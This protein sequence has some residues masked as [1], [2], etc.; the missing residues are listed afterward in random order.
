MTK[1]I[2]TNKV[3]SK[4]I[5]LLKGDFDAD[6]G[7][8]KHIKSVAIFSCQSPTSAIIDDMTFE[9]YLVKVEKTTL[10]A[11]NAKSMFKAKKMLEKYPYRLVDGFYG[12]YEKSF[13]VFNMTRL[14]VEDFNKTFYQQAYMFI[15]LIDK[16]SPNVGSG[17]SFGK[18][19]NG[20]P[21]EPLTRNGHG[22]EAAKQVAFMETWRRS[23]D[24]DEKGTNVENPYKLMETSFGITLD[25]SIMDIK[26]PTKK[27]KNSYQTRV[28]KDLGF[29]ALYKSYEANPDDYEGNPLN[30]QLKESFTDSDFESIYNSNH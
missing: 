3:L 19:A 28:S 8:F 6:K 7:R 30:L 1:L 9:K 27:D 18:D 10:Q 20:N 15:N 13:V 2:E 14:E 12:G 16:V 24:V 26:H 29:S 21:T 23:D 17:L 11:W 4:I 25:T 5:R 22:N